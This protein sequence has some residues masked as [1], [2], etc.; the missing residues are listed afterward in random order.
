MKQKTTDVGAKAEAFQKKVLGCVLAGDLTQPDPPKPDS[1]PPNL[2][3]AP[4]TNIDP[5]TKGKH[6]VGCKKSL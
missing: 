3:V 6:A 1:T 5:T 2:N 4:A